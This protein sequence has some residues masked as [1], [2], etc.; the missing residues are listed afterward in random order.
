MIL[1]ALGLCPKLAALV[2]VVPLPVLGGAALI[3]FGM[4]AATGIRILGSVELTFERLV[5]VAVSI[6]V[7]LIPVLSD[8]FFQA[9]PSALAPLLHSG[10]VLASISAVGLNAFFNGRVSTEDLTA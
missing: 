2:A 3:M 6:A 9:M 5:T 4:I 1:L 7:G 8:R 10:I